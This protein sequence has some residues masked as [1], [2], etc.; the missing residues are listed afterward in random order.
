MDW[1]NTCIVVNQQV[2]MKHPLQMWT[3]QLNSNEGDWTIGSQSYKNWKPESYMSIQY[4]NQ[5]NFRISII[6]VVNVDPQI[7]K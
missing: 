2:A 3:N 6:T 1:L 7:A 4:Q 5:L